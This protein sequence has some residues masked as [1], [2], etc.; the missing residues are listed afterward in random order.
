MRLLTATIILLAVGLLGHSSHAAV[1]VTL[2]TEAQV[3][4]AEITLG[5]IAL[6][7]G[8][9]QQAAR[10]KAVVLGTTPV[11][12]ATR[13]LRR[14]QVEWRLAESSLKD[15]TVSGAPVVTVRRATRELNAAELG[16]AAET[17]LR[18]EWG[19]LGGQLELTPLASPP[20]ISVPDNALEITAKPTG[21]KLGAVRSV[22]VLISSQG[23]VVRSI[24]LRYRLRLEAEVAMTT[25]SLSAQTT[26]NPS[27]WSVQRCDIAAL[28]GRP[29]RPNELAGRRMRRSVNAGTVLSTDNTEPMPLVLRGSH[30]L[31]SVRAGMITLTCDAIALADGVA[32]DVIELRNPSS[33][34]TFQAVVTEAGAAEIVY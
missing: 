1:S 2:Q 25:C 27:A 16:Q 32:G 8:P 14:E 33:K 24:T 17:C 34:K 23:Q 10:A 26:I 11:A 6:V 28:P 19:E 9:E 29:L 12:G 13:S 7:S 20:T 31:V 3:R 21:A 18:Q 30:V 4:G 22:N 15:F 5:E